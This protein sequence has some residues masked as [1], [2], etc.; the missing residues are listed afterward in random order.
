MTYA[1]AKEWFTENSG[2]LEGTKPVFSFT[3]RGKSVSVDS[4]M[5]LEDAT[6]LAVTRLRELLGDPAAG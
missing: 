6:I 3:V 1:Q 2:Q 4:K 5:S